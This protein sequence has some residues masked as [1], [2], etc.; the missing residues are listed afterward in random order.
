VIFS[1]LRANKLHGT[2]ADKLMFVFVN[3]SSINSK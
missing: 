2:E 1:V 3:T